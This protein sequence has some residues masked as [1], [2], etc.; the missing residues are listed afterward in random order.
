MNKQTTKVFH[1]KREITVERCVTQHFAVSALNETMAA[2]LVEDNHVEP[3]TED[4]WLDETTEVGPPIMKISVID[5]VV[6]S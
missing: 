4:V 2:N 6:G 3:E 1:I 5:S